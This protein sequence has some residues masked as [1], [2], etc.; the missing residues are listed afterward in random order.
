MLI[1]FITSFL[2]VFQPLF[3]RA[4]CLIAC[5]SLF[6]AVVF[7]YRVGCVVPTCLLVL[8]VPAVVICFV[9]GVF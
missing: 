8:S 5:C 6:P 3:L 4:G 2:V 1:S 9:P 7:V